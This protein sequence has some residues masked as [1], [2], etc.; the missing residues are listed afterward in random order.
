V[1]GV[2]GILRSS[3]EYIQWGVLGFSEDAIDFYVLR[4]VLDWGLEFS[5]T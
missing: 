1:K 3:I 4:L 2:T 5:I